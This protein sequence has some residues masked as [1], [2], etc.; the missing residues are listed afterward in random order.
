MNLN[1]MKPRILARI[2]KLSVKNSIHN[3]SARPD[4]AAQLLQILIPITFDSI[5]YQKEQF[6]LHPMTPIS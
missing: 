4:L 3:I 6:I 1:Q 2:S 5:S